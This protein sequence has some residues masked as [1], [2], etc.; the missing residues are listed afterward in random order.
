MNE[1]PNRAYFFDAGIRFSCTECG[2]CCTGEPG[3]VI[4]VSDEDIGAIASVLRLSPEEFRSRHLLRMGEVWS[5]RERENGDCQFLEQGRCSIY[6]VR[7]TQCRTYPFW[8]KNLRSEEAWARTAG[9]CPG[10]GQGEL[11][12]RESI[13]RRLEEDLRGRRPFLSE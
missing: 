2:R 4:A 1:I 10:I 7:P 13:L 12:P 5:I 9:Q 11:Y 6:A 3:A 8:F